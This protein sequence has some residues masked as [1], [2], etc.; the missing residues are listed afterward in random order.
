MTK[1][2]DF[3]VTLVPYEQSWSFNREKFISFFPDSVLTPLL[4]NN[5][6]INLTHSDVVPEALDLLHEFT[7]GQGDIT[8]ILNPDKVTIAGHYLNIDL[9]TII[10]HPGFPAFNDEYHPLMLVQTHR[11][12]KHYRDFLIFAMSHRSEPLARYILTH[13]PPSELTAPIDK[14]LFFQVIVKQSVMLARLLLPRVDPMTVASDYS[15]EDFADLDNDDRHDEISDYFSAGDV[16]E[17]DGEEN[18]D[19]YRMVDLLS[20][21][22]YGHPLLLALTHDY[23]IA[24]MLMNDPRVNDE[25][26]EILTA[27]VTAVEKSYEP[28]SSVLE[29]LGKFHYPRIILDTI[30]PKIIPLISDLYRGPDARKV[31]E[32]IDQQAIE[33]V[34]HVTKIT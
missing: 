19:Y 1:M 10:A 24:R 18:R 14:Y 26:G 22:G 21:A 32:L 5:D 23:E 20:R 30:R 29:L 34:M 28:P 25:K 2:T 27:L 4:N 7:N 6:V 3:T 13:F 12:W 9:L 11:L 33:N 15:R 16:V 31:I 17:F 8:T